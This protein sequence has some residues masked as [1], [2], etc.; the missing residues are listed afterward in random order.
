[1]GN[2]NHVVIVAEDG[3]TYEATPPHSIHKAGGVAAMLSK[4]H[5]CYRIPNG[6]PTEAALAVA[7]GEASSFYGNI[8]SEVTRHDG[9]NSCYRSAG[10]K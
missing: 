8:T 9:K 7:N 6:H 1:V 3:Y 4:P 10:S 2:S 5:V